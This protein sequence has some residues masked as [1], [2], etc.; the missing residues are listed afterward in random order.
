[1]TPNETAEAAKLAAWCE[2]MARAD[3]REDWPLCA[4]N[5]RRCAEFLHQYAALAARLAAVE[6][7]RDDAL[8]MCRD[9]ERMTELVMTQRDTAE[10]ALADIRLNLAA[11]LPDPKSPD[12][13]LA[14]GRSN[15]AD[16]ACLRA[17][18]RI[19]ARPLPAPAGRR[20]RRTGEHVEEKEA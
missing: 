4:Q 5:H 17:A 3:D 16:D 2:K 13:M 6:R 14:L 15:P 19:A 11:L 12:F 9:G 7:E 20:G 10:M 8:L 18:Y 1:M